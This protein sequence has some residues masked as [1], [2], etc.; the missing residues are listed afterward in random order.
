M[1]LFQIYI[2]TENNKVKKAL[3]HGRSVS[4]LSTNGQ[5]ESSKCE[6]CEKKAGGGGKEKDGEGR[7]KLSLR[8]IVRRREEKGS[9]SSSSHGR[10]SLSPP[11]AQT[12]AIDTL[13]PLL[14]LEG[15]WNWHSVGGECVR[16]VVWGV[17]LL[18][19]WIGVGTSRRGRLRAYGR[20]LSFSLLISTWVLNV[21]YVRGGGSYSWTRISYLL[22][23]TSVKSVVYCI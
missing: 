22:S 11:S 10:V 16:S 5:E 8:H 3:R 14:S 6:G 7:C 23:T 19:R 2:Y 1:C 13:L 18:Q 12:F 9:S 17:H 4:L 21:L 15:L 20:Y